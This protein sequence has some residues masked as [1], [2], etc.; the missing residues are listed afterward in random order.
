MVFRFFHSCCKLLQRQTYT[1]L[2]TRSGIWFCIGGLI[3]L[4]I[5]TLQFSEVLIE[6][7]MQKYAYSFRAS[8]DNIGGK[9]YQ[10]RLCL[11]GPID[12]VYTWVNGSDPVLIKELVNFRSKLIAE[13]NA[14]KSHLT[15]TA[16]QKNDP[17]KFGGKPVDNF[18]WKS[19]EVCPYPNCV[20][21][22]ALALS[23][24]VNISKQIL[25][26]ENPFL[27]KSNFYV[28]HNHI[29]PSIKVLKFENKDDY[30]EILNK[31]ILLQ[32]KMQP[33]TRVYITSTI[34]N[35]FEK[36]KGVG[37]LNDI[38]QQ[39]TE[40]VIKDALEDVHILDTK[41]NLFS[42]LTV[43]EFSD[44]ERAKRYL[45][46]LKNQISIGCQ[47]FKVM[48]ATLV[49]KPMTALE[50]GQDMLNEDISSSRF[51]DNDELK[52]S[53][54]SVD[55]YAPWVRK[56]FIVTNGQI[57]SWLNL[58]HPRI[59]IVTHE[60]LF[61][62]KSHLPTYSSPAIET[63]IHRI[64]GLSTK[65]IYMNDDVFFGD[66][67]WP[68]DFYTHSKGQKIYLTWPVP[69]CNEGCP[70]AWVNDKYCDKPCNVSEC[71]WDGGD[72]LNTKG[73]SGWTFGK[74]TLSGTHY[75]AIGEYCNGGCANSW[76]G[77][78]YC[79][80]NCNVKECGFDAGD[81][82]IDHFKELYSF[83]AKI[84]KKEVIPSG[85]KAFYIN[86]TSWIGDGI[87][88]DGEYVEVDVVR[89]AVFSKRFKVMTVSLYS[90][91]SET[92][93]FKFSGFQDTNRTASINLDLNVTV[94]TAKTAIPTYSTSSKIKSTAGPTVKILTPF[95]L[96]NNLKKR[97]TE[98]PKHR[99][100]MVR[101]NTKNPI[102][103]LDKIDKE[104]LPEEV[105]KH[106]NQTEDDFKIGDIT[107]HGY[108]K[109]KYNILSKYY[110]VRTGK[111]DENDANLTVRVRPDLYCLHKLSCCIY[112]F[113]YVF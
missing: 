72:C 95:S 109:R 32:G 31:S 110:N 38:P 70:A 108:D 64:P 78:R 91:F 100:K 53:L 105:L 56:I 46:P 60:E 40:K 52:Y 34:R 75:S 21:F 29:D 106:L 18:K 35:G 28:F 16:S 66:D 85:I 80:V 17:V 11:P 103:S 76:I 33:F 54:R 102:F 13:V 6:W 79:D 47:K 101:N 90:N 12:V 36:I 81:C 87:L 19:N 62:N 7:S 48:P 4:G 88:S 39:I 25:T 26:A 42:N 84:S 27:E 50:L 92:I 22:S 41:I 43:L 37:I 111:G 57:P 65:F 82:G 93:L 113:M 97:K 83:A 1:C 3:L 89:T 59:K 23:L 94:N 104:N 44:L 15:D 10:H 14:S 5:S 69:N 45:G 30:V 49:W 86:L 73:K 67:V 58:D 8:H 74:H 99:L 2:S 96:Y 68:D 24:P 9:S 77:D 20:S 51:A 55:K 63:H 112:S 98:I 61:L 107:Q 71:D